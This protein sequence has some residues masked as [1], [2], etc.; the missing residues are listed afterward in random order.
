MPS[1]TPDASAIDVDDVSRDDSWIPQDEA[2][3]EM[4]DAQ[5]TA[6][7]ERTAAWLPSS[8]KRLPECYRA[9]GTLSSLADRMASCWWGCA[10]DDH[11]A[12]YLV[13]RALHATRA[14][15]VLARSGFYDEALLLARSVGE[16]GN[17]MFL[18]TAHRAAYDEWRRLDGKERWAKFRPKKVRDKLLVLQV[19]TPLDEQ[20]YGLLSEH[21]AHV[22]PS[23][24]PQ[25]Y[26]PAARPVGAAYFQE[27][28]LMV[29]VNETALAFAI[30]V[31]LA[32]GL[33]QLPKER[34]DEIVAAARRVLENVGG[35]QITSLAE[36]R[37]KTRDALDGRNP[38]HGH[39]TFD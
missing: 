33:T 28:G 37:A 26:N 2:F 31:P 9:L 22:T 4:L 12:Q 24:V 13:G 21:S 3:F 15:L 14:S 32:S 11:V 23:L 38:Q 5:E 6:C 34:R 20:R 18:F 1:F 25:S 29:A 19:P 7:R 36:F 10:K 35:A 27:L 8:G 39:D 30:T 17:L 16:I